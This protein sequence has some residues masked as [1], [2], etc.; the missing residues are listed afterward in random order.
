V[1]G[2]WWHNFEDVWIVR[3]GTQAR[4]WTDRLQP[5]IKDYSSSVLV[6]GLPAGTERSWAYFGPSPTKRVGWLQKYFT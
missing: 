2:W 3:G 6:L 1:T 5:A 4:D